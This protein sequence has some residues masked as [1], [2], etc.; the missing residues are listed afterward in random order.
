MTFMGKPNLEVVAPPP[1]GPFP[2]KV[3]FESGEDTTLDADT[4]VWGENFVRFY[5]E[6]NE[7]EAFLVGAYRNETVLEV[8]ELTPSSN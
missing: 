2:Y 8:K 1:E 6:P 5:L 3:W 4:V 7:N